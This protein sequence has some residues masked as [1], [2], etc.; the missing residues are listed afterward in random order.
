MSSTYKAKL[1]SCYR[2]L[3]PFPKGLDLQR[4]LLHMNSCP[5]LLADLGPNT[6]KQTQKTISKF[7]H[8]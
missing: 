5:Q 8:K 3:I 1:S 2:V 6:H 4:T 7:I